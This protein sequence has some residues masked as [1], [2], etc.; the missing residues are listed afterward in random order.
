MNKEVQSLIVKNTIIHDD[1][2][3]PPTPHSLSHTLQ[4]L[5]MACEC[6]DNLYCKVKRKQTQLCIII[7]MDMMQ[8]LEKQAQL[9]VRDD[10]FFSFTHAWLPLCKLVNT[11]YLPTH[12]H[13]FSI[14][15][16]IQSSYHYFVLVMEEE[17]RQHPSC[18]CSSTLLVS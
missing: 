6:T 8:F 13:L 3:R 12:H 15:N 17:W 11:W 2:S 18:H 4:K 10:G 9:I 16:E 5:E 7:I 1:H 14:G